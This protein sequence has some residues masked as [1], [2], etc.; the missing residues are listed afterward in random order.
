M[1][2]NRV[3]IR[4]SG[5][6]PGVLAKA[7]FLEGPWFSYDESVQMK[8]KAQFTKALQ[9]ESV[10]FEENLKLVRGITPL[11]ITFT[12]LIDKDKRVTHILAE[13]RD[14]RQLREAEEELR[15][16]RQQL[17]EAQRI[18]HVGSW[19]WDI[20]RN[21]AQWSDELFRIFGINPTE[22]NHTLQ[23]FLN[24]VH[25]DDLN[26]I[27]EKIGYCVKT[28]Q[29]LHFTNRIIQPG[30]QIRTI[31]SRGRV[32][33][34]ELG[35]PVRMIG[36]C[37]DVTELKQIEK[38]KEELLEREKKAREEAQRLNHA[39]DLF[40]ATLS[41]EL[42]NPLTTILSWSQM[43]LKKSDDS[44]LV[45]K[46][47]AL[48]EK[49]ANSQTVMINDLLD[50]SRIIL[51]KLILNPTKIDTCSMVHSAVEAVKIQASEKQIEVYTDTNRCSGWVLADEVRLQQVLWNLLSNSIRY[52][53]S[54]GT[55]RVIAETLDQSRANK[56]FRITV[57]DTGKGISPSFLPHL[58]DS[59]AQ[60]GDTS[61]RH[62]GGLGIGLTIVKSI[63]EL[64]GGT[65]SAMSEGEGKGATFVVELP[66]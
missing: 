64:H 62:H 15:N 59:L 6:K 54:G 46:G 34:D 45:K 12:P 26:E 14:L 3:A 53:P 39:K 43:L 2:V 27:K 7:N 42:K 33:C 40:L 21:H 52:T 66:A 49:S 47:A 22:F 29:P 38:Q 41:H 50:I 60:E 10:S 9:G 58:F 55:I 18:S 31:E 61:A 16:N 23:A 51:S 24:H 19:E 63:V 1:L 37:Q 30:G 25:P 11:L 35:K 8:V 65:I 44:K 4:E 57:S 13:G 36:T 48:I 32:I 28:R 17:A 56:L 5:L 20:P